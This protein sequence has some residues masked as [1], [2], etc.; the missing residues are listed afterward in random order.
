M[1][2]TEFNV[3]PTPEFYE[4]IETSIKGTF[5]LKIIKNKNKKVQP[6]P[7]DL[8][9]IET[10]TNIELIE[11][12]EGVYNILIKNV[13][14][15]NIE[16]KLDFLTNQII[17]PPPLKKTKNFLHIEMRQRKIFKEYF[18]NENVGKFYKTIY[19]SRGNKKH[20]NNKKFS[21]EYFKENPW[22]YNKVQNEFHRIF[23]QL[24]Q[25]FIVN[26]EK[27]LNKYRY[28]LFEKEEP[29]C[30]KLLEKILENIPPNTPTYQ[31]GWDVQMP[32]YIVWDDEDD[33]QEYWYNLNTDGKKKFRKIVW[34]KTEEFF[35][36]LSGE[37]KGRDTYIKAREVIEYFDF[38]KTPIHKYNILRLKNWDKKSKLSNLKGLRGKHYNDDK[39]W[40]FG[41]ISKEQIERLAIWNGFIREPKKIYK[42]KNK[43]GEVRE[44]KEYKYGEYAE[45]LL[46]IYYPNSICLK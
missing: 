15:P 21:L 9:I 46:K 41:G 17:N 22:Y 28:K 42:Q 5:T 6:S 16:K 43:E 27:D 2:T 31:L 14:I 26:P 29:E 12:S 45:F 10:P 20:K 39:N 33:D 44:Y 25:S 3:Y 1:T 13:K 30:L 23:H 34:D 38:T 19:I 4:L 7:E 11:I 36:N 32:A 18:R 8:N 24:I 40:Y 35:N 37:I